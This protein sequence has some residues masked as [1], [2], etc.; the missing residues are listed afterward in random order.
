MEGRRPE[1]GVGAP[2]AQPAAPSMVGGKGLE[3]AVRVQTRS[4]RWPS[5]GAGGLHHSFELG[6]LGHG[7]ASS[8]EVEYNMAEGAGSAVLQRR[9][10]ATTEGRRLTKP[11]FDL[12]DFASGLLKVARAP[13]RT[14][15]RA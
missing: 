3:K 12:W 15:M 14:R 2:L 7:H 9:G 10:R 11:S 13:M 1:I 6:K 8:R 5:S 4:R